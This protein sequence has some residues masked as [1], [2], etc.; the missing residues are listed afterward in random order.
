MRL[1]AI[2]VSIVGLILAFFALWYFH[3]RITI[4]ELRATIEQRVPIGTP[5]HQVLRFLDSLHIGHSEVF[6]SRFESDFRGPGRF[7]DASIQDLRRPDLLS[8]GIFLEFRFDDH[9]LLIDYR[10]RLSYTF[11]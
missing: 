6:E 1:K 9:D 2:I 3:V 8:D 5:A 7:V 10:V 4:P 11:L